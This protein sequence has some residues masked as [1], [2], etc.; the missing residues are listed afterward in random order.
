ILWLLAGAIGTLDR[1]RTLCLGLSAMSVPLALTAVRHF[2]AGDFM[3]GVATSRIAGYEAGLTENPN[4]LALMLNLLLPIA[5]ALLL[6]RPRGRLRVALLGVVAVDVA[7]V[8]V[9]FSRAGFLT[10]VATGLVWAWKLRGRRERGYLY[11]VFALAV[12]CLPLLPSGYALRL[13]TVLDTSSDPTGSAQARRED[14]TA[15]LSFIADHPLGRAGIGQ[16]VLALNA[17]RGPRWTA[18]HN[19]YLEYA[20]DLGLPGLALFVALLAGA[21]RS[22]GRVARQTAGDPAW[23]ELSLL[24]TGIQVSL[25]A[26]AVG[27]MF[28][29]V[30]YQFY[31][32]YVAGR[33]VALPPIAAHAGAPAVARGRPARS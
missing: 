27:G 11:A 30:S 16:G 6:T 17:V 9:T 21:V 33:A 10:L 15:A 25:L 26:F 14:M 20:V 28:H 24:A 18:V 13:G 19:V 8:V 3:Q 29:P 7:G 31:F 12:A 5:V 23:C 4:D 22:A 32:Y 2:R 1:L